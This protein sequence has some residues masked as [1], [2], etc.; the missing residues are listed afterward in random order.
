MPLFNKFSVAISSLQLSTYH[1]FY[2]AFG[3]PFAFWA[4][5]YHNIKGSETLSIPLH[6]L[7]RTDDHMGLAESFSTSRD[8]ENL[9]LNVH[10]NLKFLF[11]NFFFFMY[12]FWL[13]LFK[14]MYNKS[15]NKMACSIHICMCVYII[16]AYIVTYMYIVNS[17]IKSVRSK[18][19]IL[20]YYWTTQKLNLTFNAKW[21]WSPLSYTFLL[22]LY[23]LF[24]W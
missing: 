24:V 9:K 19:E 1:N 14:T 16:Y 5:Y 3:A 22:F 17:L 20:M 23:C 4:A 18:F 7:N 12:Y 2:F 13:S 10:E 8:V 11:W 21:C 15:A 6:Y